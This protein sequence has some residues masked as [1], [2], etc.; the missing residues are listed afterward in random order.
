M[1]EAAKAVAGGGLPADLPGAPAAGSA[2]PARNT[3]AARVAA[4]HPVVD[5]LLER[6][7]ID[8]TVVDVMVVDERDRQ[9]IG[10]PYLTVAID[11]HSRCLLGMVLT[12]EA[13][14]LVDRVSWPMGGKPRQL[15]LDNAAEFKSEALRRGCEQH[16]IE[17]D[18]RPSVASTTRRPP[19]C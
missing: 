5:G 16:G 8:H 10:R 4:L 6:V 14:G 9:P 15:Y 17:L 12:L 3:V 11:V 1:S 19:R 2:G 13:L 18:Y 7:Q